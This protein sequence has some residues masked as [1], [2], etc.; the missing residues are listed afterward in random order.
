MLGNTL[1]AYSCGHRYS[2]NEQFIHDSKQAID[3]LDHFANT[4][5]AV[6]SAIQDISNS[7][8]PNCVYE[9]M[10]ILMQKDV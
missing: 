1:I 10:S 3:C 8:C 6:Q 2:S 4:S 7:A 5:A 9:Q